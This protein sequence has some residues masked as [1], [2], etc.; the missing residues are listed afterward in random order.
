[1]KNTRALINSVITVIWFVVII[2][3]TSELYKPLKTALA[4]MTGHH[5]VT[6]SVLAVVLLKL[7][8]LLLKRRT[9]ASD[10]SDTSGIY[11]VIGSAVAGGLI[12]FIFFIWHFLI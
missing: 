5:W 10:K 9:T 11:A 2:T 4:A 1:M 8:Y 7:T 6:K 12:I 3:I